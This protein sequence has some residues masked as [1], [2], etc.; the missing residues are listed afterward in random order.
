[1]SVDVGL[2][3]DPTKLPTGCYFQD[4]CPHVMDICTNINPEVYVNG[5][6]SIACHLFT[7]KNSGGGDNY[8][9]NI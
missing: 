3:P 2:M 8:E 9:Q 1:M 4:R 5:T 6:H 7:G